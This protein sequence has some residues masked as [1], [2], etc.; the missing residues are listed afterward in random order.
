MAHQV[1]EPMGRQA[2]RSHFGAVGALPVR[3]PG[4]LRLEN[5]IDNRAMPSCIYTNWNNRLPMQ[6]R[7]ARPETDSLPDLD[8]A[9]CL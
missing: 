4:K 9:I 7:T 2:E 8:L 6:I 1:L 3:V 5:I